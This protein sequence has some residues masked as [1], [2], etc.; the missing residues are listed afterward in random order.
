MF[1]RGDREKRKCFATSWL[2]KMLRNK[3]QRAWVV[4]K[5]HSCI[6]TTTPAVALFLHPSYPIFPIQ[7]LFATSRNTAV[8]HFRK[9]MAADFLGC[10]P[11]QQRGSTV[12]SAGQKHPPVLS[13]DRIL[14]YR[15][16]PM[17]L[18]LRTM[19]DRPTVTVGDSTVFWARLVWTNSNISNKLGHPTAGVWERS[20]DQ[21]GEGRRLVSVK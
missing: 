21:T 17:I 19:M 10:F 3:V 15:K 1:L 2:K 13:W 11:A 16:R 18:I 4:L 20:E 12:H 7:I 9:C 8:F 14:Q 5:H 6:E